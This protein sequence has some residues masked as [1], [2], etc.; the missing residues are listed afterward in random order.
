MGGDQGGADARVETNLLVDGSGIGLEGAGVPPLGLAK[1]RADQ[2]IEQ[3]DGLVGQAGGKCPRL[4]GDQRRMPRCRFVAGDMLDGGAPGLARKLGEARLMDQCP[5]PGS[6]PI[7][8]TCS[9]RSITP[10][11]AAGLA[12][13]GICR[14]QVEPTLTGRFPALRSAHRAFVAVRR[15]AR[16]S[17]ADAL[18]DGP[19][20]AVRRR[21]RSRAARRRN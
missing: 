20:G 18:P 4:I 19:C 17:A 16:W 7:A 6:M 8:R 1:H 12:A 13:S 21:S 9:R 14:N 11:M 10:S 5:R 15:T 3:I 2:T